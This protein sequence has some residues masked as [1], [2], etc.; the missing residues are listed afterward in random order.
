MKT[1]VI[2]IEYFSQDGKPLDRHRVETGLV[3]YARELVAHAIN[4]KAD[5]S[6]RTY[7][8]DGSYR[9][10]ANAFYTLDR[11]YKFDVAPELKPRAYYGE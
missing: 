2:E 6:V 10:L 9:I 1:F 7:Q 4:E 3:N 11:E 5:L 8:E